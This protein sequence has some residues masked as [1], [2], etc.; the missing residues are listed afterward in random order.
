MDSLYQLEIIWI[1]I[2]QALGDWL[3]SPMKLFSMLGNEEFYLL[4]MPILYW[5]VDPILGFR[6]AIMLLLSNGLSSISKLALHAPRPYW[7]DGQVR[8]LISETSF[9]AP[10]GHA[11]NAASIWGLMAVILQ[12][13]WVRIALVLAIALIGLSRIYLGVH[14]ISDVL[15]GW[16]LGGLLLLVYLK[17]ERPIGNWLRTKTLRQMVLLAL[18][19][20]IIIAAA[21]LLTAA[22]LGNWSVPLEWQENALSAVPG[23]DIHPLGVEGAFTISGTWLGLMLGVAWLFHNGGYNASGSV[24]QRAFR[25]VIGLIGVALLWYGLGQIFPRGDDVLSFG[26]RFFRYTLIGLW[27]S[28]AAPL[29]F[30]RV[31]LSSGLSGPLQKEPDLIRRIL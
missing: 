10:S 21:I 25:S 1:L 29:L 26:L 31:G 18:G 30:K 20:S 13:T 3:V 6:M 16:L 4:I 28:A 24:D 2:V 7:I 23:V 17:I 9:G 19:S 27:V 8:A 5:S 15:L 12:K 11:L 22:S 14:F